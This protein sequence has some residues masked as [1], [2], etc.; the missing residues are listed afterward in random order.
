[1]IQDWPTIN[2]NSEQAQVMIRNPYKEKENWL[3]N[4]DLEVIVSI[5]AGNQL[6]SFYDKLNSVTHGSAITEEIKE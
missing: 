6:F 2:K 5:F 1:M 3:S 4:G